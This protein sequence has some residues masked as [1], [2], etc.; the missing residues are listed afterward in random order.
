ME[1]KVRINL[2][3][4]RSLELGRST[5]GRPGDRQSTNLPVNFEI[6]RFKINLLL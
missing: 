4:G 2:Y 6:S 3:M 5:F 1:K